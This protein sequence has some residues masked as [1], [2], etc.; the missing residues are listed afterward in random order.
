MSFHVSVDHAAVDVSFWRYWNFEAAAVDSVWA[1]HLRSM[2]LDVEADGVAVKLVGGLTKPARTF[3][4]I[5]M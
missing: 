1:S 2:A 5:G 4:N 3:C